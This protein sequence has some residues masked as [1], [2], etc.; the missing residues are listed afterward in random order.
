MAMYP[1]EDS[2]E[3]KEENIWKR[4]ELNCYECGKFCG[5]YFRENPIF[6]FE[7][8]FCSL[9]CRQDHLDHIVKE[10]KTN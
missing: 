6:F 2:E 5:V 10:K 3:K 1:E 9:K 4:T 7:L 8:F